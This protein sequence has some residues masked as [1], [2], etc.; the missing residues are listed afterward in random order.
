MNYKKQNANLIYQVQ[1]HLQKITF[2]TCQFQLSSPSKPNPTRLS[3]VCIVDDLN[4]LIFKLLFDLTKKCQSHI[5]DI[6]LSTARNKTPL[7]TGADLPEFHMNLEYR[8]GKQ[9]EPIGIKTTLG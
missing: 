6:L 5:Q 3:N 8:H 7:I 1:N 9:G 4:I 2:K